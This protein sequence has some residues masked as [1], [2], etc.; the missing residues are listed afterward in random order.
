M[1]VENRSNCFTFIVNWFSK[2]FIKQKN[3]EN[4]N[5]NPNSDIV[6]DIKQ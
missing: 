2:L 3:N 4:P 5:P 6:I 1:F